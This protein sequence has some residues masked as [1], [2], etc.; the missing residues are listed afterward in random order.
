MFRIVQTCRQGFFVGGL[1]LIGIYGFAYKL[2]PIVIPMIGEITFMI[3]LIILRVYFD[4]F[5]PNLITREGDETQL[6]SECANEAEEGCV[7]LGGV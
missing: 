1:I 4:N 6:A 5:G 7:V 2:W 3:T